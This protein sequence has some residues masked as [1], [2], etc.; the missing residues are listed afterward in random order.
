MKIVIEERRVS[1]E[2]GKE[3][4]A[5]D[6]L[7]NGD[8]HIWRTEGD[9]TVNI[10][11]FRFHEG[12]VE[13]I[14]TKNENGGELISVLGLNTRTRRCL[15]HH[16]GDGITVVGLLAKEPK[17]LLKIR[18]FWTGSLEEV[19][20]RLQAYF[21]SLSHQPSEKDEETGGETETITPIIVSKD[22]KTEQIHM[23]VPKEREEEI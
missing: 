20:Q 4:I 6:E 23:R 9:G 13:N 5:L 3:F 17:E 11:I 10:G 8:I 16:Y 19:Q 14:D 2:K 22:G 15:L 7:P 21:D 1:L 18:G 12:F